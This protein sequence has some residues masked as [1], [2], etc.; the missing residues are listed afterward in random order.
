MGRWQG[1]TASFRQ[2][3][4]SCRHYHWR[5]GTGSLL[6]WGCVRGVRRQGGRQQVGL[7]GGHQ[8]GGAS[9]GALKGLAAGVWAPVSHARNSWRGGGT[10]PCTQ[11]NCHCHGGG[12]S[13]QF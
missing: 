10:L 11:T 6:H 4:V 8:R 7:W 9:H 2:A 5:G 12:R 1:A 13:H 3:G